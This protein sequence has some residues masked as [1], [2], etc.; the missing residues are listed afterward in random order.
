[1]SY[2]KYMP[3]PSGIEFSTFED[4]DSPSVAAYQRRLWLHTCESGPVCE[5]WDKGDCNHGGC[6]QILESTDRCHACDTDRTAKSQFE[7]DMK[8]AYVRPEWP[9]EIVT[10]DR[11]D[12][13]ED[14]TG[15]K[16]TGDPAPSK[17]YAALGEELIQVFLVCVKRQ[18]DTTSTRSWIYYDYEVRTDATDESTTVNTFIVTINGDA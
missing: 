8:F 5:G 16:Y 11:Y 3:L 17:F 9:D 7:D 14:I 10:A 12:L 13:S 1:M 4:S 6:V 15:A 18:V 2:H